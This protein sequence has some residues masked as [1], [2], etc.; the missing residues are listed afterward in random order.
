[1]KD[2]GQL[3]Y[4]LGLEVWIKYGKTH[5][6]DSVSILSQFMVNPHDNH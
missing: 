4:C 3:H 5:I 2:L 1:M 6:V